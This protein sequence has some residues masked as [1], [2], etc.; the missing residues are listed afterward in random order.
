VERALRNRGELAAQQKRIE[1]ARLSDR[2]AKL[3]R[4]P[5]LTGYGDYGVLGSTRMAATY[6]VR[7]RVLVA[8]F[9]GGRRESNRSDALT[10]VRRRELQAGEMRRQIELDVRR[11]YENLRL[12]VRQIETSEQIVHLADDELSHAQRRYEAGL[13]PGIEIVEAQT[14]LALSRDD[15]VAALYRRGVA[16]VELAAGMGTVDAL[17]H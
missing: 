17:F 13:L 16:M 7:V 9:D 11:A 8:V 14:R 10:E 2:A 1:G 15:R 4:R 12:A 3:E 6:T 5:L